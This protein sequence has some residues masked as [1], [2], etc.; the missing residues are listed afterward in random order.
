MA[1]QNGG[2]GES[3]KYA[4]L[5]KWLFLLGFE[6]LEQFD[7]PDSCVSS[8]VSPSLVVTIPGESNERTIWSIAHLDV[9]PTGD[10]KLW[11]TNPWECGKRR[12]SLWAWS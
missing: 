3:E 11:N 12:R 5:K 9:I 10:L 7:A 1:P 6:H 2:D 8:G 4:D